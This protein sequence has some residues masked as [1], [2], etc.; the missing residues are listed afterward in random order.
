MST[1]AI[2][3]ALSSSKAI[4]QLDHV[5]T[6]TPNLKQEMSESPSNSGVASKRK[7]QSTEWLDPELYG[8]RRSVCLTL[9]YSL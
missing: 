4:E 3:L 9:F 7:L 5:Q 6:E 2:A 1:S 8:L